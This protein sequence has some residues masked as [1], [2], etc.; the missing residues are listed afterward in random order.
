M[1]KSVYK[2][3]GQLRYNH[4]WF[5]GRG[6]IISK[7]LSDQ[8]KKSGNK[9]L[10]IGCGAGTSIDILRPLG[11]VWGIDV[12]SQAI[13]ESRNCGYF[14]LEKADIGS[15]HKYNH[16]F[17]LVACLDVLEHLNDDDGVLK[18]IKT[19]LKRNGKLLIT[20]PAFMF[21]WSENDNA[22]HHFRR[23]TAKELTN[24][25]KKNGFQVVKISYFNFL[26]FPMFIGWLVFSKIVGLINSNKRK[27]MLGYKIPCLFNKILSIIFAFEARIVSVDV[28]FGLSIVCVAKKKYA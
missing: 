8:V 19:L 21:L 22:V 6:K 15:Y 20:V 27:S 7:Y 1:D 9:V 3:A 24:K 12:S 11:Q 18:K 28:P 26:L 17:D 16:F 23:Y 14:S 2:L 10:D 25:L 5:I 4:W 13:K